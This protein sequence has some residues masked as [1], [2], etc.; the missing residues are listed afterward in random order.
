MLNPAG[1]MLKRPSSHSDRARTVESVA[2][3]PYA[4]NH[5]KRHWRGECPHRTKFGRVGGETCRM[6][7]KEST[8]FPAA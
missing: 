5:K 7:T 3:V 2:N 6:Q 4:V 1:P 8:V